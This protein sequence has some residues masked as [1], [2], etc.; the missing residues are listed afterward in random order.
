VVVLGLI[1]GG[2]TEL[3]MIS[4]S[5]GMFPIWSEG[6]LLFPEGGNTGDLNRTGSKS[7]DNCNAF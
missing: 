1:A 4:G 5:F 2:L 6:N 7:L 3:E